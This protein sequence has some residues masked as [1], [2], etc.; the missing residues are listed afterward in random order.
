MLTP[1]HNGHTKLASIR[2][3]K[4]GTCLT[5]RIIKLRHLAHRS[6]A[7]TYS[8]CLAFGRRFSIFV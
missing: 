3:L 1:A 5:D 6:A 4:A 8:T 2:G 7:S